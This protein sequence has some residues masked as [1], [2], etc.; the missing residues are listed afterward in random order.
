MSNVHDLS[1]HIFM[2][3]KPAGVIELNLIS[4]D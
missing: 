4:A 1:V 3:A 2:Y